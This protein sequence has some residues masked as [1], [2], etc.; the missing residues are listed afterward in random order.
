MGFPMKHSLHLVDVPDDAAPAVQADSLEVTD[1]AKIREA[2]SGHGFPRHIGS[3]FDEGLALRERRRYPEFDLPAKC[4]SGYAPL[5]YDVR[6]SGVA[7]INTGGSQYLYL[8]REARAEIPKAFRP[9]S[10]WVNPDWAGLQTHVFFHPEAFPANLWP[11]ARDHFQKHHPEVATVALREGTK[12]G[13]YQRQWSEN[14]RHLAMETH[15]QGRRLIVSALEASAVQQNPWKDML[16]SLPLEA[17]MDAQILRTRA[18]KDLTSTDPS[19]DQWWLVG[20][21]ARWRILDPARSS[22][23][24]RSQVFQVLT[25]DLLTSPGARV[26]PAPAPALC[27]SQDPFDPKDFPGR[28]VFTTLGTLR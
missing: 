5:G 19:V 26:V 25:D 11:T 24:L 18:V 17:G 8:S 12:L 22:V 27:P 3:P 21:I 13:E 16:F 6:S 23:G 20:S 15:D 10:R 2:L 1:L 7:I 9:A 4:P 14:V 28:E